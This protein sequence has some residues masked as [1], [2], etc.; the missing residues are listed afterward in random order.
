MKT[1][2][3]DEVN[4]FIKELETGRMKFK[5]KYLDLEKNENF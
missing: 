2:T 3:Y 5:T 4:V 1:Y